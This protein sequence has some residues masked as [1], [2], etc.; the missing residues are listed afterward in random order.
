MSETYTAPVASSP[1]VARMI[2]AAMLNVNTYEEVEADPNATSQ[3]AI[4]V[5]LAAISGGIVGFANGVVF[6]VVSLL[7]GIIT[8]YLGWVVMS[9]ITYFVGTRMFDGKAD[10]GELMRTLGFAQAPRVASAIAIVPILGWIASIVIGFWCL[11]TAFIAIRQALDVDNTK[12]A[13]TAV[14]SWLAAMVVIF[15]P[16]MILASIVAIVAGAVG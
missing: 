13:I 5:G 4:V 8:A 3:A 14:V 11:A 9:Y 15:I 1:I 7:V 12:A 6:G 16:T 2:G 10:V